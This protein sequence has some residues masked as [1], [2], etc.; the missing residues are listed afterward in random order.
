MSKIAG[1]TGCQDPL[2][3]FLPS[4]VNPMFQSHKKFTSNWTLLSL[5]REGFRTPLEL[6]VET[7]VIRKSLEG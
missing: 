7:S 4:K 5:T 2:G 6:Q 1:D 3:N